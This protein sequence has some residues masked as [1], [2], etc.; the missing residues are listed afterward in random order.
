MP[1]F[2]VTD[3]DDTMLN[4]NKSYIGKAEVNKS[5]VDSK[6]KVLMSKIKKLNNQGIK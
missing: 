5:Y 1:G 2:K 3:M 6:K 4:D